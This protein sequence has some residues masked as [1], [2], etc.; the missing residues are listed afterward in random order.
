VG[1]MALLA[2][3]LGVAWNATRLTADGRIADT[4]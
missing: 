3:S 1:G 2:A 4:D